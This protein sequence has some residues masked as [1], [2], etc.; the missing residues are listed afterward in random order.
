MTLR[1]I[2]ARATL[3]LPYSGYYELYIPLNISNYVQALVW[4]TVKLI[5]VMHDDGEL[6]RG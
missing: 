6:E 3:L 4:L 5:N 2:I 1:Y